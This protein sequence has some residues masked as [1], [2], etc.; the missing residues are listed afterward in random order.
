V[1]VSKFL[2]IVAKNGFGHHWIVGQGT[3][4]ASTINELFRALG[5]KVHSVL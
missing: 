5:I 3:H 2:N 4:Y 1:L